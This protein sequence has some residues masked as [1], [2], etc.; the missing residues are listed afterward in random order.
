MTDALD[1]RDARDARE[2]CAR[3]VEDGKDF[4]ARLGVFDVR[5]SVPQGAML[6]LLLRMRGYYRYR[7][8]Y[9]SNT[10]WFK[11]AWQDTTRHGVISPSGSG[12]L[13]C[14]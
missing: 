1:A 14:T 7:Y 9:H 8:S 11:V 10:S 5:Q 2:G 4:R 12:F 13:C 6:L 3:G